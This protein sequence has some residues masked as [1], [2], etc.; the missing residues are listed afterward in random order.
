MP[1]SQLTSSVI[2]S[3]GPSGPSGSSVTVSELSPSAKASPEIG[4]IR[5]RRSRAP[6]MRQAGDCEKQALAPEERREHPAAGAALFEEALVALLGHPEARSRLDQ[7]RDRLPVV[8]LFA[9]ERA[10]RSFDLLV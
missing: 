2:S 10:A 8:R 3:S 7:G 5:V 4:V 6:R 9:L 1:S